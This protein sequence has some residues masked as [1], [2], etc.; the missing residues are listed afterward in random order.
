[1]R[2]GQSRGGSEGK[3]EEERKEEEEMKRGVREGQ[4]GGGSEGKG[5]EEMKRGVKEGQS[6]GGSETRAHCDILFTQHYSMKYQYPNF[7]ECSV[8]YL[9]LILSG[10]WRQFPQNH[11]QSIRNLFQGGAAPSSRW[12]LLAT[13][14]LRVWFASCIG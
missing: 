14:L 9:I 2:E 8:G 3:G 13:S 10:L 4:S 7:G 1:V 6:R 12:L 5:E 11:A